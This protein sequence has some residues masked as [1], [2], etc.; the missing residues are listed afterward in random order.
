MIG[1]YVFLTTPLP[2]INCKEITAISLAEFLTGTGMAQRQGPENA[3]W[4]GHLT[5]E[6]A[7]YQLTTYIEGQQCE[8]ESLRFE[9]VEEFYYRVVAGARA[10][11]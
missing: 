1:P 8:Q 6:G 4:E 3:L 9:Q 11:N 5:A 10:C 7:H 2:A